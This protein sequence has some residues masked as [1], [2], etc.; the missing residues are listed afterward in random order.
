LSEEKETFALNQYL[1]SSIL[2]VS[3]L[4]AVVA[5]T[6][7]LSVGIEKN[8]KYEEVTFFCIMMW[9]VFHLFSPRLTPSPCDHMTCDARYLVMSV[10]CEIENGTHFNLRYAS[11]TCCPPVFITQPAATFVNCVY[12]GSP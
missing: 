8:A 7:L 4:Q 5:G 1:M 11:A 9:W 10:I 2:A 3:I 6:E 12:K